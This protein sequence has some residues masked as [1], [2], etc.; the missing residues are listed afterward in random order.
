MKNQ[1]GFSIIEAILILVIV[2]MIGGIGWYV[3]SAQNKVNQTLNKA[4]SVSN[5]APKVTTKAKTS[6][7]TKNE[8]LN[9]TNW[10]MYTN[11]QFKYSYKYP[12]NVN[13]SEVCLGDCKPTPVQP[14]SAYVYAVREDHFVISVLADE[15]AA[16]LSKELIKTNQGGDCVKSDI[17]EVLI[18]NHPAFKYESKDGCGDPLAYYIKPADKFFLHITLSATDPLAKDI[19]STFK[20]TN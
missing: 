4:D 2:G 9:T 11:T 14:T 12:N 7:S 13:L 17:N 1:K 19:L 20:I 15:N 8:T 5:S 6:T 16:T 10:S 3:W 18:D